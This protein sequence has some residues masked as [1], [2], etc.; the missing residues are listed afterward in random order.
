MHI[1]RHAFL[2]TNVVVLPGVTIGEGAVV[3]ANSLV[4]KDLKPWTVYKGSPARETARRD[5]GQ[6]KA[7]EAKAYAGTGLT[8]FDVGPLLI[9]KREMERRPE[10]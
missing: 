10:A 8:P 3:G 9:L 6:V 4:T 7:L 2:G 1:G 5:S